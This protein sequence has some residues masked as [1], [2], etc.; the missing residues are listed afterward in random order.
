MAEATPEKNKEYANTSRLSLPECSYRLIPLNSLEVHCLW[1]S[2]AASSIPTMRRQITLD[3]LSDREGA[4]MIHESPPVSKKL[5]W[6][7]NAAGIHHGFLGPVG[8]PNL[9]CW[10]A[11]RRSAGNHSITVSST[12][13]RNQYFLTQKISGEIGTFQSA[14]EF[15]LTTF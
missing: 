11:S 7:R 9:Y 8:N 1:H 4:V 13:V 5:R 12:Y 6:C 2:R 10:Q 3:F 15:E 14:T